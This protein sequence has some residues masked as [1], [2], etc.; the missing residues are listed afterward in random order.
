MGLLGKI[1]PPRSLRGTSYIC[2]GT[3]WSRLH[4]HIHAT[5]MLLPFWMPRAQPPVLSLL[6]VLHLEMTLTRLRILTTFLTKGLTNNTYTL[7]FPLDCPLD[8]HQILVSHN[9]SN[10]YLFC[11]YFLWKNKLSFFDLATSI[12]KKNLKEFRT[13]IS[14]SLDK[15]MLNM[16]FIK[17]FLLQ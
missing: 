11:I 3:F 2:I 1:T 17:I 10:T 16:N 4:D 15:E 9:K 5:C 12:P 6:G 13:L 8:S 7:I 14:N